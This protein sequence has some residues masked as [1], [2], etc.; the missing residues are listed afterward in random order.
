MNNDL[1]MAYVFGRLFNLESCLIFLD[2][3]DD[4]SKTR[5]L[6]SNNG[7]SGNYCKKSKNAIQ[8]E[9]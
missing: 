6:C 1:D 4:L 9:L 8:M 3:E 7:S 5:F 2:K